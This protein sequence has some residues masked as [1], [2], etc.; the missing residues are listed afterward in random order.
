LTSGRSLGTCSGGSDFA[1]L[2]HI[3]TD[4]PMGAMPAMP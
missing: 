4:D 2:A 3:D 1:D